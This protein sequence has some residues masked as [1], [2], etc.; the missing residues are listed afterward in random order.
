MHLREEKNEMH[1]VGCKVLTGVL[2][3]LWV[4]GLAIAGSPDPEARDAFRRGRFA[5]LHQQAAGAGLSAE[6]EAPREAAPPPLDAPASPESA[7][8]DLTPIRLRHPVVLAHGAVWL[9][10]LGIE[11]LKSNYWAGIDERLRELGVHF[12]TPE[13]TPTGS[14]QERAA[15]L[16]TAILGAFPKGKV[17]VI[18][19]SMGGLDA[20]YMITSL[21][22][23]RK[24]ASLTTISTPHHGSYYADFARKYIFKW[25]GLEWLAGKAKLNFEAIKELTVGHLENYFNPTVPN[26]PGVKYYSYAGVTSLWKMPLSQWGMKLVVSV[27]EKAA[28]RKGVGRASRAALEQAI[29]GGARA[30]MELAL[31]TKADT[32]WI[33]PEHAGRSDGVVSVSSAQWGEYL[34]EIDAHHL[35]QIGASRR[36]DHAAIWEGVVRKLE[37][38]GH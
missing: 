32:S 14:I 28:A 31:S 5:A 3:G 9:G 34:G 2:A 36:V 21:G 38:L 1:R 11:K 7:P 33:L 17:N 16:R 25:Q 26:I 13:V 4:V 22:M 24:V 12:I 19:H 18:A 8:R 27:A 29:P 6:L 15:Q 23:G 37:E 35:A 30:A 20:R 10:A